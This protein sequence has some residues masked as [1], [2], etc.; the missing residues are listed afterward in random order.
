MGLRALCLN[1]PTDGA[2]YA[3]LRHD[4]ETKRVYYRRIDKRT[5][6][7]SVVRVGIVDG[8]P[9]LQIADARILRLNR[10]GVPENPLVQCHLEKE[11]EVKLEDALA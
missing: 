7:L 11:T 3:R 10:A 2:F 4:W 8:K 6:I 1:R 9:C 5:I